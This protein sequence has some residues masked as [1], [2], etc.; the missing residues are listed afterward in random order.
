MLRWSRDFWF[1]DLSIDEPACGV[2][3]HIDDMA[4]RIGHT[5]MGMG[6]FES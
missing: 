2:L 4:G 5:G 1:T 6:D 3:V